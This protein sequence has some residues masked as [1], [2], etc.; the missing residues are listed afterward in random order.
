MKEFVWLLDEVVLAVHDEQLAVHGGL[1]GI[2][3]RGAVE[4]ALTHP[5]NLVAYEACDNVATKIVSDGI[6]CGK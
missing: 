3:D 5:R 1:A 6:G 2:R 4:S